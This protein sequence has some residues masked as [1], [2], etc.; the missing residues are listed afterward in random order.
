MHYPPFVA[1]CRPR[2]GAQV[3]HEGWLLKRGEHIKNWRSRYFVL[4]DDGTLLGFKQQP[5]PGVY[6]DPL[7]DFTV[8]RCQLMK[9]EGPRPNTFLVR[10]LQWTTVIERTFCTATSEEREQWVAALYSVAKKLKD[11]ETTT[12]GVEPVQQNGD[13]IF[14]AAMIPAFQQS[15]EILQKQTKKVVSHVGHSINLIL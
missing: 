2:A 9:V 13:R 6:N 10:G 12:V 14:D 15:P 5:A 3:V 7:N 4:F 11:D 8:K 1:T